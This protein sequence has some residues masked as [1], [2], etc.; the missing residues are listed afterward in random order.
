MI[1]TNDLEIIILSYNA[2]FWLKKTLISLERYFLKKTK[3]QI[4]VTVVD[5]ES[6]DDSVAVAQT[7][8]FIDL[9]ESGENGGFAKGNNIALRKTKS[10][11]VMLLNSDTEFNENSNLDLVIEY[12]DKNKKVGALTPKLILPDGKLDL[13]SHRGE[14]SLWASIFYFLKMDK[15]FL[16]KIPFFNGYHL[17]HLDLNKTHEVQAISGAAFIMPTKVLK[18]VGYLDEQ[19]FMYAEDLDWCHRIRDKGFKIIYFPKV[20][21]IHHKNKSGIKSAQKGVRKKINVYF[22]QTM[23]QYYDKYYQRKIDKVG[24]FFLNLFIKF[25]LKTS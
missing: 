15:L 8:K 10:R 3:Y 5:N 9:I 4:K 12:L 6:K 13:G 17:L 18:K 19:F 11:Y 22:Y 7:F 21:I 23:L 25:K 14:P 1:K 20:S 16:Q 24:R 2:S